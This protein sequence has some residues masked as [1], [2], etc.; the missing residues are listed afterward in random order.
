MAS[1]LDGYLSVSP[2]E[3]GASDY[4]FA[5]MYKHPD[6]GKYFVMTTSVW[7][8]NEY[9][10]EWMHDRDFSNTMLVPDVDLVNDEDKHEFD[11]F[12]EAYAFYVKWWKAR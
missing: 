6:N 2:S 12:Q 3:D 7:T 5:F 1:S 11:T 10:A 8:W 4:S 9:N